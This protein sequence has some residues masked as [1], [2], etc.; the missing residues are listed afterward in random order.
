MTNKKFIAGKIIS[1]ADANN[2]GLIS[3]ALR[4]T[5]YQKRI[6]IS[7]DQ[8]AALES[9][10]D[11]T[12]KVN[13]IAAEAIRAKIDHLEKMVAKWKKNQG[14]PMEHDEII[15]QIKNLGFECIPVDEDT[16]KFAIGIFIPSPVNGIAEKIDIRELAEN[17]KIISAAGKKFKKSFGWE[18]EIISV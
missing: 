4:G 2:R 6:S 10:F 11:T 9:V 13:P 3:D 18:A 12:A 1:L 14:V 7:L 5:D 16:G 17:A 15:A 8:K